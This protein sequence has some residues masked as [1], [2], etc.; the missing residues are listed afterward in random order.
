MLLDSISARLHVKVNLSN[1]RQIDSVCHLTWRLCGRFQISRH[2]EP[3][4]NVHLKFRRRACL[5]TQAGQMTDQILDIK[6][7]NQR[8]RSFLETKPRIILGSESHSRKCEILSSNDNSTRSAGSKT[9]QSLLIS[10][11]SWKHQKHA[12]T[13]YLSKI[14]TVIKLCLQAKSRALIHCAIS[15]R[16]HIHTDSRFLELLN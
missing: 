11:L 16:L 14:R 5:Q 6:E 13:Y 4:T 1:S 8:F 2:A 15:Q 10:R 7:L 9:T 12:D 3:G